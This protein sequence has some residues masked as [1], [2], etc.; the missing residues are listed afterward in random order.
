[1]KNI[2]F[3]AL[4]ITV[5][6]M[7]VH[8]QDVNKAKEILAKVSAKYKKFA[9][10]KVDLKY[11]LEIQGDKKFKEQQSGTLYLKK[12]KFK[13]EMSDQVV[14][15]DGKTLWTYIKDAKEVQINNFSPKIMDVNPAEIFTMYEK[16]YLYGYTG[17]V[18]EGKK[19]LQEIELTPTDK[20]QSFFKVK[21]YI[22]KANNE[23]VKFKLYEKNGNIYTYEISNTVADSKMPD[24]LF[25]WDD[26]KYP[27]VKKVDL[28]P[29]K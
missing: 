13:L 28:R 15:S 26:K 18:T 14:I 8:A 23:I 1:M 20:K 3:A 25:G 24:T 12:P 10:I 4:C 11:I 29:K 2:L 7:P 16:G 9:T 19:T 27:G 5:L 17:E 6:F 22:N 21:L